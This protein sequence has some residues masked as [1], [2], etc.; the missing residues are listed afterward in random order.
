VI[1]HKVLDTV[2]KQGQFYESVSPGD[3]TTIC[4]AQPKIKLYFHCTCNMDWGPCDMAGVHAIWAGVYTIWAGV[5]TIWAGVH[6]IWAG[7]HTV[8]AG[9]M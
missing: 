7:V 6:A 8:W 3:K 4:Q 5:H 2:D 1:G 9:Y